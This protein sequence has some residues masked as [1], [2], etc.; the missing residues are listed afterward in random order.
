MFLA[1]RWHRLEA[2]SGTWSEGDPIRALDVAILQNNLLAPQLGITDPRTDNRID[3]VG[4]IHGLEELEKRVNAGWMVA[5]VL[6]P[7]TLD[8]LFTVADAGLVMP[9]KS[10]WFEPK[11]RC[12]LLVRSLDT[13]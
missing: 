13:G 3:F 1:G 4:G 6:F 5:F 12:G 9:P 10:T 11:L 8:Q 2:K 7:A